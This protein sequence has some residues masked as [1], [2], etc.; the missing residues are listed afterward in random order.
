LC[1]LLSA[2]L[3]VSQ[4]K[5]QGVILD[6]SSGET[7]IGATVVI[8][9]TTEG[10]ATDID[11]KF[12]FNTEKSFPL[13]LVISFV[14]YINQELTL[15][16]SLALTVRLKKNEVLLKDITVTG[17]RISEKQKE[18]PL[19]V[20]A[21]DYLAIKETPA[22]N[23]YE[24][25]GQLKGVDL[26]SAS[27]GFKII[28]TRGF[29]SSSP[30]R[31]LQIIDGV[32]NQS[33]GLNFS[34][35]NFLG[36]SELDVQ[37][38]DLVVGASSAY[39]GPNAFNGVISMTTRNPFESPGLQFM[40]KI[41]ERNL[42]EYALR[43]AQVFKNKSGVE[44]FAYKLNFFTMRALDWKADNYSPTDASRTGSNNPG[45]YDAVNIY[46][47]E[48][49]NGTDYTRFPGA[50][51]GLMAYNRKGYKEADLVDYNSNNT[52][53]GMA[54]HYKITPKIETILAS[55]FG[56]GTT[57]YQGDNRYSL[58]DIKFL[59]NRFEIRQKDK[60]FVRAYSTQEDAGKSYDAYFTA[61][62]LQR[63]AKSD[64]D[65]KI[66][67]ENFWN[68][69]YNLSYIRT[70]PGFPQPPGFGAPYVAWLQTINPFLLN[71]Y[72]DSLVT[73]HQNAQNY[74]SGAGNPQNQNLPYF[75]PGTA[76]FDSAFASITSRKSYKEGGSRFFDKSSLYHLQG[77]Y[78][79]ET[80]WLDIIVGGNY[81]IYRPNSDGTIFSDTSFVRYNIDEV[82]GDTLSIDSLT[83]K[84]TNE[85]FGFYG[86]LEKK[87]WKDRIKLN[88]T[89]RL[90]KNQNFNYLFSPAG[91]VVFSPNANHSIRISFSSAIRNP[92]LT[93][94]YLYYQV[95]RAILLGNINGY[96]DLLTTESVLEFYDSSKSSFKFLNYFDVDPVRP[97]KVKTL[98]GGYRATLFKKLYLDVNGYYSWYRDFIGYQI[99]VLADTFSIQ[100]FGGR[101]ND[102][103]INN[104]VRV[105]SNAK[106][107]VTT[108]GI[109][110]GLSYYVGKY[111]ALTGNYSWNK[112][113][114][115]GTD[116]PLI[117]AFNTPENKFN[118]GFNGRDFKGIGF[119]VNYKW[120]QG[121]TYEGSP[122]FSGKI[123][124]YDMVDAQVNY[125]LKEAGT[126]FKVGASNVLG[127]RHYEIYGGPKVGRLVYFSILFEVSQL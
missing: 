61:L 100:A 125:N 109:S 122:Q 8:K 34:L 116:D 35:G 5:I 20:E 115:K 99:G 15:E 103:V 9:G 79:F 57:I 77:E 19:T 33:P 51:P 7:L 22:A 48:A 113:N 27:L 42:V 74:A 105:A 102:M 95:G 12:Q 40:V 17:S 36:S 80:Q 86:G 111:F 90:D 114:K 23:F 4:N 38:V 84:I 6:A 123:N 30:V 107:E 89:G 14:G 63:Q 60:W 92:T 18:S 59:Q 87:I 47:D 29:N 67:Y 127:N 71:N 101:I 53:A 69:K 1:F 106:S 16:K 50:Y 96:K 52:K 126:T 88:A 32:D 94:Q 118:I 68:A 62:L 85:E 49:L 119:N 70:L 10:A 41:G 104:A 43:F 58:K 55:N 3:S 120:V 91:S 83:K 97:E 13:T 98:E 73:F 117:P 112:L 108:Q 75:E 54:L 39:F 24:G 65:W 78:K 82:N 124:S 56:Y 72:Y 28:N 66:D 81:R 26:T 2:F 37:K 45:G 25:L 21:M 64:G 76:A 31:S 44:K 110:F 11:G 93:D 121:F 46:G